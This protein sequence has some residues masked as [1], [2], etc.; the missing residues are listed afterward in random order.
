MPELF[1]VNGTYTINNEKEIQSNGRLEKL[2][3]IPRRPFWRRI[4]IVQELVLPLNLRLLCGEEFTDIPE[5]DSFHNAV[6]IC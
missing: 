3:L 4:W 2:L 1:T 6:N 5:P